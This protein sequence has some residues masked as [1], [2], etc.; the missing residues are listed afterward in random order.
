[1]KRENILKPPIG[2]NNIRVS[3]ADSKFNKQLI[4]IQGKLTSQI[5]QRSEKDP[6]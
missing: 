2:V 3:V 4:K 6:Y 1:M 5:R